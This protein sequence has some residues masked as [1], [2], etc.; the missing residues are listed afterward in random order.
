MIHTRYRDKLFLQNIPLNWSFKACLHQTNVKAKAQAIWLRKWFHTHFQAKFVWTFVDKIQCLWIK[1]FAIQSNLIFVYLSHVV[2]L[3]FEEFTRSQEENWCTSFYFCTFC[4]YSLW[5]LQWKKILWW[6][7]NILKRQWKVKLTEC[8][9]VII[10]S[11]RLSQGTPGLSE[12]PIG[13]ACSPCRCSGLWSV[14]SRVCICE[15]DRIVAN[16]S[17]DDVRLG[18]LML[19]QEWRGPQ[20]RSVQQSVF[21]RSF[22]SLQTQ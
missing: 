6:Q 8:S 19:C 17:S 14:C 1:E 18:W 5:T 4:N 3:M 22:S 7:H 13:C 2:G 15:C 11:K 21:I 9:F 12:T 16:V 20:I 10:K